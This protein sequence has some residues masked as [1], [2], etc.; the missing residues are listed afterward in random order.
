MF[1]ATNPADFPA[2]GDSFS[3]VERGVHIVCK[4]QASLTGRPYD[5]ATRRQDNRRADRECELEGTTG[6]MVDK[7]TG[8]PG[9]LVNLDQGVA[10]AASY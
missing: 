4:A 2:T 6:R 1:H 9:D 10:F 8:G 3:L 5:K 7:T